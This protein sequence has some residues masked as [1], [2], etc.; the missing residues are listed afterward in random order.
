M[1]ERRYVI[2]CERCE[3]YEEKSRFDIDAVFRGTVTV[4]NVKY[5]YVVVESAKKAAEKHYILTTT[6]HHVDAKMVKVRAALN[7]KATR[8]AAKLLG[9]HYRMINNSGEKA[10][11]RTHYHVHLIAPGEGERLPRA[12]AN[13]QK[14]IKE[15]DVSEE[16]KATLDKAFLHQK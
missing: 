1:T 16:L 13:V 5:E 7:A 11:S 9:S 4:K 2:G 8:I 10:S 12:V 6:S 3:Q 14:V 15:L